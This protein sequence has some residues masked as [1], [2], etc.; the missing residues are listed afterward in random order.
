M[1][2][3]DK[4]ITKNVVSHFWGLTSQETYKNWLS[5]EVNMKLQENGFNFDQIELH[6]KAPLNQEWRQG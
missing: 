6:E 2:K 1:N 5:F 4:G 3:W